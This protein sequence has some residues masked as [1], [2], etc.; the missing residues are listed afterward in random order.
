MLHNLS[1]HLMYHTYLLY[2]NMLEIL[3]F[4]YSINMSYNI[5]FHQ[6]MYHKDM[7]ILYIKWCHYYNNNRSNINDTLHLIHNQSILKGNQY[8]Y[9]QTILLDH[10]ILS[11]NQISNQVNNL[12]QDHLFHTNPLYI[13]IMNQPIYQFCQLQINMYNKMF[14]LNNICMDIHNL[15][16]NQ[17]YHRNKN[18]QNK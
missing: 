18:L 1:Q 11:I 13:D 8:K 17:Q 15:H 2:K 4:Q 12:N 9:L 16:M 3:F 6:N 5:N 10:L 14:H 7:Y